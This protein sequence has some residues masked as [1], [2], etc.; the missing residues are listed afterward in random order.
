MELKLPDTIYTPEQLQEGLI[1]LDTYIGI[2]RN[3]SAKQKTGVAVVEDETTQNLREKLRELL[4]LAEPGGHPSLE[5]T[6]SL[7]QQLEDLFQHAPVVHLTLP[8]LPGGDLRRKIAAWLR[9]NVS[10]QAMVSFHFNSGLGGGFMLRA[11]SRIYDFSFRSQL[12]DKRAV[13]AKL[14]KEGQ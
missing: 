9:Q 10:A 3:Q 13:L 6:E 8:D 2:L 12:F 11:G 14:M 1:N 5:Q 7:M 4:I